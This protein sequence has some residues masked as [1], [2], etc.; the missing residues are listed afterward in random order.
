[1]ERAGIGQQT[2]DSDSNSGAKEKIRD[3]AAPA[4]PCAVRV[5]ADKGLDDDS[6]QRRE[7][8]EE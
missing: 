6:H 1:M 8:P 7:N 5:F 2:H 3:A 4:T